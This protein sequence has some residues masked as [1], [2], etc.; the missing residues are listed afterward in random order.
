MTGDTRIALFLMGELVAA[1]R[2]N[3]PELFRQ[4]LAGGIQVLGVSLL[5]AERT[6]AD[7][8]LGMAKKMTTS[9]RVSPT[10]TICSR[11]EIVSKKVSMLST[12]KQAYNRYHATFA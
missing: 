11:S 1:L 8:G 12:A 10:K 6:N 5:P 3:S 7:L 4:W 9:E 2:A